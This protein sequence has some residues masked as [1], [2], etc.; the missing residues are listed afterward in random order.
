MKIIITG[1]RGFIGH[2]LSVFLEKKNIK[3]LGY[4][5][6]NLKNPKIFKKNYLENIDGVIH[7]AGVSRVSSSINQPIKT[8]NANIILTTRILEAIK[9]TKKKPWFMFASTHQIKFDKNFK[10]FTPYSISKE[11]CENIICFYSNN[12][13]IKSFIMR[14]TDIFGLKNY[15]EHKI[16]GILINNFKKNKSVNIKTPNHYLNFVDIKDLSKL[17]LS[18]IKKKFKTNLS[19]LNIESNNRIKLIKFARQL[20][21]AMNSTS[22]IITQENTIKKKINNSITEKIIKLN[23]NVDKIIKENF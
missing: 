20:K 15:D 9:K 12:Y 16:L 11:T 18:T 5:L 13:K 1:S 7:L 19:I 2:N 3:V 17:I 22:K 10:Q 8:L 21:K 4:D 14:F 23:L 6:K